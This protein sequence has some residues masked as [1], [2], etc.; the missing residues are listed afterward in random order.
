[1]SDLLHG[2]QL[3]REKELKELDATLYQF[4]HI[5]TGLELV[6]LKRDEENKS[7][8][9]A[10]ETLPEND[11]G[12]FH[13]L[14]HST[15]CGSEKFPVKEPFV[16][17]MKNSMNTFLNALTFPD[18]TCYPV[19]SKNN[20]DFLNL[21]GVYLDA[22]FAPSIY[23][24]PEIFHQEGWHYEFTKD[25]SATYNGV[26]FNEM[27]GVYS[28]PDELT[29]YALNKALF[30]NNCYR[31]DYGGD[32]SRIPDLSYEEFLHTHERF[33]S[34]SNAY[35]I[36]DGKVDLEAVLRLLDDDYLSKI[37]PGKRLA[38]PQMQKP[39]NIGLIEAEYA[40]DSKEEEEGKARLVLG[41]V[42]GSFAEREKLVAA[43]ILA[44]VLCG[45]NHAPL[46]KAVLESGLAED[47]LMETEGEMLQPTIK[48]EL[49][50][51]KKEDEKK[52]EE[53]V[54]SVLHEVAEKGI[55][56]E[57][58][59]AALANQQFKMKEGEDYY[60]QGVSL[61]FDVL[62]SWL[63]GGA[64]EAN[65]ECDELFKSLREKAKH[66]WFEKLINELLLNNPHACK[67]LM[68][69]SHTFG[70]RR[71]EAEDKRLAAELKTLDSNKLQALK[72]EQEE[73]T[74]WQQSED[75]PEALATM[76]TL[77]LADVDP[78][79][80]QV[81]T[82][83]LNE[84]GLCILKHQ[85][86]HN[87]VF[88]CN[89]YFDAN[90]YSEQEYSQMALLCEALGQLGTRK[91]SPDKLANKIRRL[92]GDLQLKV[93]SFENE[94][95][96]TQTKLCVSYSALKEN[97]EEAQELVLHILTET[98]FDKTK[99]IKDLL[100]QRKVELYQEIMQSGSM[101]ALGHLA[102]SYTVSGVV[103]DYANG[104]CYY[105]YL[106]S[107]NK[108]KNFE[109]LQDLANKI[110]CWNNLLISYSGDIPELTTQEWKKLPKETTRQ[111]A[112]IKPYGARKEG[113]SIP[114][115]VSYATLGGKFKNGSFAKMALA[116]H[117]ISLEYLW[118]VVR[119][120]GGAYGAGL[121]VKESGFCGCYSYRDPS[122]AQSLKAFTSSGAFL[123]KALTP[124]RDL[125]GAIIGTVAEA[126]PFL[127][128]KMKGQYADSLYIKGTS[129]E[130]LCAR[131]QE[132]LS[133]TPENLLPVA[134][135]LKTT[136]QEDSSL[137]VIGPKEQLAKCSG[138]KVIG[139]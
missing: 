137:C 108:V 5:R 40:V 106:K 110:F 63:Y 51:L 38:P 75:S 8:C 133:T 2:F 58:L 4:K 29:Q 3:T 103:N 41:G 56:K 27:K 82:E 89:L 97:A 81:P 16:E 31:F 18:K 77:C 116:S 35:V 67:I 131:R 96:Q 54:Y 32:P 123:E 12:V 132:L 122:A 100:S 74:K 78:K 114:S 83:I 23:K 115:E 119:V 120:Q 91:Y 70:Q 129:Y 48:I 45:N 80:E 73:L 30:P 87:G 26:V 21:V 90:S 64:P 93:V 99:E 66:G 28:D 59:E 127:S 84:E 105:Q 94:K 42:I 136:L 72:Q 15:L 1:M 104:I 101:Y 34:P 76:P 135:L 130:D 44:E 60:T 109:F 112:E 125:S 46:C 36:L 17:L 88:Y 111:L 117:I 14:E 9:I 134:D 107:L 55:D 6:W 20:K 53:L 52:A 79:P 49:R 25:G 47:V 22:V 126:S 39:V 95:N 11:T 33:Y 7:F 37:K 85:I 98:V 13:I 139:L 86:G 24:K 68:L 65:L 10:F 118:N 128:T 57:T 61:A 19:S 50:N 71:A 102:S 124:E 69:P 43:D 62:S 113:F 138:I 92:L 121:S